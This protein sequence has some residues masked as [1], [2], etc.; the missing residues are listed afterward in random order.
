M[1]SSAAPSSSDGTGAVSRAGVEAPSGA[2]GVK[3]FQNVQEELV[4]K[5]ELL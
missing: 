4:E 5:S 1:I 3:I 2:A